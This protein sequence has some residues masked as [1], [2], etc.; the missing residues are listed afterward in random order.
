MKI[1]VVII[2]S[3]FFGEST[4]DFIPCISKEIAKSY[5]D[6]SVEVIKQK[7][8][9]QESGDTEWIADNVILITSSINERYIISITDNFVREKSAWEE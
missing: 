8:S 1:W 4:T 5:F 6:L 7:K 3:V 2:E 9:F